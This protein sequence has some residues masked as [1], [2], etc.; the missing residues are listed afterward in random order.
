MAIT[1][2]TEFVTN[3]SALTITGVTRAYLEPPRQLATADLP[4]SYV[5]IPSGIETP[6]TGDATGGW[7][8]LRAD[9]VVVLEPYRQNTQSANYTAALTMMDSVSSALRAST[10]LGKANARWT[11]RQDMELY[12]ETT[13]WVIVCNVESNG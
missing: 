2:Y 8:T 9:L 6:I 12:G 7:P 13:Y 10:N 11:I 4:T 3:L 1:T 5:R